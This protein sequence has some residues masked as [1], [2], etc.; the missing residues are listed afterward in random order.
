MAD[1]SGS[2][3]RR[4]NGSLRAESRVG[5]LILDH[6]ERALSSH[7]IKSHQAPW[8]VL[9]L[10]SKP[11]NRLSEKPILHRDT[12]LKSV[13]PNPAKHEPLSSADRTPLWN[14]IPNLNG[15]CGWVAV[16][17]RNKAASCSLSSAPGG[18]LLLFLHLFKK[19]LCKMSN[20]T[21][22]GGPDA[23]NKNRNAAAALTSMRDWCHDAG[24]CLRFCRGDGVYS[25]SN[26]VIPCSSEVLQSASCALTAGPL[27][28]HLCA[29]CTVLPYLWL[30]P[31]PKTTG[32]S[33]RIRK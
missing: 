1:S 32:K 31:P 9:R 8:A 13:K 27:S 19:R 17:P 20:Q 11:V 21:R 5:T 4:M 14:K 29:R 16:S 10:T 6:L 33:Q 2:R 24:W 7:L 22:Q 26:M 30:S 3:K 15:L 18:L 23:L 25:G 12:P 28:L